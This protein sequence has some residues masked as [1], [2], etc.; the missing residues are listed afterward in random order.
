MFN[1]TATVRRANVTVDDRRALIAIA[2]GRKPKEVLE[3]PH[4]QFIRNALKDRLNW[5]RRDPAPQAVLD[6]AKQMAAHLVARD[7]KARDE[8]AAKDA[9]VRQGMIDAGAS[10]EEVAAVLAC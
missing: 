5:P 7:K 2:S 3:V 10:E 1:K 4:E 6:A 9:A 8:K